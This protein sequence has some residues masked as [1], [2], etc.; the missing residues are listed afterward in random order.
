MSR[1]PPGPHRPDA[2]RE[3]RFLVAPFAVK[4][5]TAFQARLSY[6]IALL[7][8]REAALTAAAA[9]PPAGDLYVLNMQRR[10]V[11][12]CRHRR[13]DFDPADFFEEAA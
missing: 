12:M 2:G 5:R 1:R 9:R 7:Q 6:E 11:E 3:R 13:M 8:Q 4:G 10:I